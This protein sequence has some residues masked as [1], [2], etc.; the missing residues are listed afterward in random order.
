MIAGYD[1]DAA[2]GDEVLLSAFLQKFFL[3]E[4][5][6]MV[7]IVNRTFCKLETNDHLL[8]HSW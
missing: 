8:R 4:G 1:D 3:L 5:D 2:L 7:V 6:S